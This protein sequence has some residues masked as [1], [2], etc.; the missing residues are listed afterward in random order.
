MN[1]P[2][3]IL[4]PEIL[5]GERSVLRTRTGLDLAVRPVR[6]EDEPAIAAFFAQVSPDDRRFRFLT[7]ADHP[8][9][10]QLAPLVSADHVLS[11]SY[12]A[13]ERDSDAIVASGLFACD[14]AGETA[15]IAISVRADYRGQGVGWA[16]LDLLAEAARARGARRV[17][18]IESRGNHAAIELE[19]E[20]GFVPSAVDGDP[21]LVMLTRTFT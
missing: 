17:I 14:N 21:G 2:A 11:E 3:R 6:P 12:I 13:L 19:R 5:A 18:S 1:A 9:H 20:K 10:Q 16:L 15:E 8:T 4:P 7:T